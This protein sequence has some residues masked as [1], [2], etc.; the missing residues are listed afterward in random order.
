VSLVGTDRETYLAIRGLDALDKVCA[1]I[2]AAASAGVPVGVRVTLQRSNF[3]QLPEFVNLVRRLGARHVSFLAVDV[4]NP[5]AFGRVDG[6]NA[7]LALHPADLPV[8]EQILGRME[9]DHADDFR[10][11]FIEESPVRM[12]NIHQYFAAVCGLAPFPRVRCNAPEFSAVLG[13]TGSVSPCFFIQGPADALCGNDL[14]HILN[15]DSM[16][17]LRQ[18]IRSGVRAE[19]ARCVCSLWREPESRAAADFL[20]RQDAHV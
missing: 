16:T 4:A 13:A 9:I 6:F 17:A 1:G 19:C 12:R 20:P 18:E 15:S 7:N 2:M 8:L 3:R 5:H 11:G 10:S 14:E